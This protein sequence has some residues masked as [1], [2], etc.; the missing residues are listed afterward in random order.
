[1]GRASKLEIKFLLK[2]DR[3]LSTRF[4]FILFLIVGIFYILSY[5]IFSLRKISPWNISPEKWDLRLIRNYPGYL[6]EGKAGLGVILG[7][8]QNQLRKKWGSPS[9]RDYG[10]PEL[11]F[12]KNEKFRGH[13]LIKKGRII[14]IRYFVSEN[15]PSIQWLTALGLRQEDIEKLNNEEIMRKIL[16]LYGNVLY[17]KLKD[18][19]IIQNRGIHFLFNKKG[20]REIRIF[21]PSWA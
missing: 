20:I 14:Q 8:T 18:E 16:V 17:T 2:Y 13:F 15:I 3:F 21:P 9:N 4:F 5:P 12:Y 7:E 19:L 1:M 10:S 6:V 11:L